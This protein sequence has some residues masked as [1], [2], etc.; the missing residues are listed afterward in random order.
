[1][2]SQFFLV[3]AFSLPRLSW[4]NPQS[5]FWCHLVSTIFLCN[6]VNVPA[7]KKIHK[8]NSTDSLKLPHIYI[9]QSK[10]VRVE[11]QFKMSLLSV[12]QHAFWLCT[13][14]CQHRI[15]TSSRRT[16]TEHAGS[17]SAFM[18]MAD[19]DWGRF[20]CRGPLHSGVLQ[21]VMHTELSLPVQNCW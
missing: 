10:S 11:F 15:E 17:C 18:V 3:K 14:V 19:D 20:F 2:S 6:C 5:W 7:Q 4:N 8:L 21:Q 12:F 9:F 16:K 1:M 13:K